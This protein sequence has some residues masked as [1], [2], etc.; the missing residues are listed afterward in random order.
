MKSVNS[1]TGLN[2]TGIGMS[3]LDSKEMLEGR[4]LGPISPGGPEDAAAMRREYAES[5]ETVGAVPSPT[6]VQ[7]AITTVVEAIKG[8]SPAIFLD[9]L[10]ERLAFE[11][12]GTR[13]YEALQL[14][15]QA[16]DT[17][18]GG[19]TLVEVQRIHDE[20][21]AH[22][23]LLRAAMDELGADPTAV[24]P[25]ADVIGVASMGLLQVITDP[26]T[27]LPQ[28]LD[29]LLTAELTDNDGWQTLIELGRTLGK[30]DLVVE[31][32][33]AKADEEVHLSDVRRW[34]SRE[35]RLEATSSL[36]A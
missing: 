13:L 32:E 36:A 14:K 30:D 25:A 34:L 2:R 35:S 10:G 21:L 26:R 31:L 29:A 17:W 23:E 15:L 16:S 22:F 20:E 28:C 1:S 11:R 33:R 18:E 9:K 8:H 27:T 6:T 5:E 3:P 7:G 19:P 12:T 24:T 4:D